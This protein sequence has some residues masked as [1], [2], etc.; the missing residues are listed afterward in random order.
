MLVATS[1]IIL[2]HT[3]QVRVRMA[4]SPTGNLHLGTAYTTFFNYLFARKNNGIFILRFEDTDLERSKKAF[5]ENIL[6]G[7]SWLGLKWDEEPYRQSERLFSYKAAAEKLI[8]DGKAYPCFCTKEELEAEKKDRQVLSLPQI[9][10]GKCRNLTVGE[11]EENKKLGKPAA[12]RFK[13]PE[14]RGLIKFNDLLHGEVVFDSKLLGDMVILRSNGMPLYN[15]AVVVDDIDMNI[16]HVLLGDDHLSNTPKQVVLF[17]AMG[18]AVPEFAH[19]P[20][21]LNPDRIGKLSKRENAASVGDYRKMGFLPEAIINYFAL[22]GWTMPDGR[23]IMSLEEME[24]SF[25]LPKM[26]LSPAA[27]DPVKFEWLNGE[28]IRQL[29][30]EELAK[31]LQEFLV[32][33][34]AKEK[35]GRVVPLIKER[36]KKL[37]DFVPLTDFF[38]QKP[39]YDRSVFEKIQISGDIQKVLDQVIERLQNM[40]QP[41]GAKV[42]EQTFRELSEELRMPVAEMFQLIRV[43]VSGK[44]VT[45]PLFESIQILGE[46]E[47]LRRVEHVARSYQDLPNL[48]EQIVSEE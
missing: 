30:D 10:S 40:T 45:P 31:R 23:E 48:T 39:D 11:V 34:P 43:S 19:W 8:K 16:T 1:Y 41:W 6:D 35:I 7:I 20:M 18:A 24:K 47:S 46:R 32:D 9:Y 36:I 2:S 22:L 15:F 17:E 25:D 5:E 33:H 21:I 26:R 13:M 38:W 3:M 4:P 42:F 12:I 29:S 28:Y 27:F 37:S 14:D 44:L